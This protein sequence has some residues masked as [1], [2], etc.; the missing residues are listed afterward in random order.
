MIMKRDSLYLNQSMKILSH[1]Q[2]SNFYIVLQLMRDRDQ[3]PMNLQYRLSLLYHLL[4]SSPL[5]FKFNIYFIAYLFMTM[6]SSSFIF[7]IF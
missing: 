2:Y 7:S 1:S 5:N 4:C 6:L 3:T